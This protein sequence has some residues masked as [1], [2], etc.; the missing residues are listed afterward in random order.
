MK[1]FFQMAISSFNNKDNK[2]FFC[3]IKRA[4]LIKNSLQLI[5]VNNK[6]YNSQI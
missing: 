3:N 6:W 1:D 4:L 5:I 2:V